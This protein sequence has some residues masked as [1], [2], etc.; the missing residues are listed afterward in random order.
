MT[1]PVVSFERLAV[2]GLGLLGGSVALAARESGVAREIAAASRSQGPL[3]E[4][5][6]TG[7][8]DHAGS[9]AEAVAGAEMVVLACPVEAMPGLVREAAPHLA[10]GAVVT[11]L[12]SVKTGPCRELPELLPEGT[13]F[14]GAHPMAGGHEHGARH[15]R[16]DIFEG[17]CC[18]VTPSPETPV[19]VKA[20]VVGFW[21]AL[22][23]RVVER[24]AEAH[25]AEVAWVSHVPHLVAFAFAEALADAPEGASAL[26]G[27]GLADF[28]RIA[29]GEPGLWSGI[30]S[31]NR[32]AL[33]GPLRSFRRALDELVEAVESRDGE[34][35]ERMM[36]SA[37]AILK[38]ID[39]RRSGARL[40]V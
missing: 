29:R 37:R 23:A 15:A 11:D 9:V 34:R 40:R 16:A 39:S 17:A 33:A 1:P 30:L 21:R 26:A 35:Q 4:A 28:T 3:D 18:V 8:L 5:L 2:L 19:D 22:G 14:V 36:G 38:G 6:R 20:R 10:P 25:D 32:E 13:F 24:S 27:P 12:G 31:A 7:M